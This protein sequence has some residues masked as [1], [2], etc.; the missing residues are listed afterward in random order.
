MKALQ[1]SRLL[2][3]RSCSALW[4]NVQRW[5]SQEPFCEE[6]WGS[7]GLTLERLASRPAAQTEADRYIFRVPWPIYAFAQSSVEIVS[8]R[9]DCYDIHICKGTEV[10]ND[11]SKAADRA[12]ADAAEKWASFPACWTVPRVPNSGAR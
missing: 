10:Q 7:G 12:G 11:I 1:V 6:T 8:H 2:K 5:L 3:E 9:Y 4:G